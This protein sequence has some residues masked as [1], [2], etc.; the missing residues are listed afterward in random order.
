MRDL[1]NVTLIVKYKCVL[2]LLI[3]SVLVYSSYGIVYCYCLNIAV[4]QLARKAV[5]TLRLQERFNECDTTS[6]KRCLVHK[7]TSF[8]VGKLI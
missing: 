8:L 5:A 4:C 6:K 2:F 7:M 1:E 3:S